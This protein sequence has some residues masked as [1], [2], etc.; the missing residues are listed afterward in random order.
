ML[1][2]KMDGISGVP[3]AEE[4]F[5]RR[6]TTSLKPSFC[7]NSMEWL[8]RSSRMLE[9]NVNQKMVFCNLVSRMF[10]SA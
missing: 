6:L 1:Q 7:R 2:Q 3:P 4:L 10:V 9:R 8:A 5:Y